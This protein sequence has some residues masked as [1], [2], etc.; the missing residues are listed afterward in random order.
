MHA[1]SLSCN[2]N[3]FNASKA[4]FSPHRLSQSSYPDSV[5][6]VVSSVSDLKENSLYGRDSRFDSSKKLIPL[7]NPSMSLLAY[8]LA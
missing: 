6:D 4:S 1:G 3:E 7:F 8:W 2:A 5:D